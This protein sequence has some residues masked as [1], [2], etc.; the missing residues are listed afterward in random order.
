[1]NT[2]NSNAALLNSR[3]HYEIL[4]GLRG[5]AA[6]AV[7]IYHCM[8]FA[9]PDYHQNFIAHGHLAVDFFFCLS[10]FVIAYAYDNRIAQIGF[11]QFFALRLIRL[12]PLVI[13]G[14][15]I[16]L[17]TFLFDPYSNLHAAYSAGKKM[18]MFVTSC[19][20]IPWPMVHERYFN[21]FH[22]NPPTWSLFWEYIANIFYALVLYRLRNKILWILVITGAIALC[23]ESYKSGYL[24]VGWGGDNFFGGG[25]RVFYSF[26][27][28]MLLY[29]S[30]RVIHSGI[31]FIPMA[32]LLAIVFFIPF[33]DATN[34]F[35]D[36]AIV[37]F[38]FPLLV[39]LGAGAKLSSTYHKLCRFLG[40]ISYPLYMIHYPFLW[41]FMSYIEIK[42]PSLNQMAVIIPIAVL[43]L[44]VFAYLV[45]IFLDIPVRNYLKRVLKKK[46]IRHHSKKDMVSV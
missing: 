45:M 30:N 42:K 20:L 34:K 2:N 4:D 11:R 9:V 21:F 15:V 37:I 43:L 13:I 41:I 3:Q 1:M 6:I 22:L 8:E 35:I 31:G 28:G 14:S 18:L 17:L 46:S 12:H 32:L 39:A 16:G 36:P 19:F 38:Y 33:A 25:I 44:I 7:V 23:Y 5:V 40:D 27:A 10:G 29:R 24:G 26:L